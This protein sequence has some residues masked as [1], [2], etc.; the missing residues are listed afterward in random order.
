M[1]SSDEE[2]L[3]WAEGR[4]LSTDEAVALAREIRA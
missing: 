4:R 3:I 1:P 2:R